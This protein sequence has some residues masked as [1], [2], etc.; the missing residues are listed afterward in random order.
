MQFQLRGLDIGREFIAQV[1]AQTHCVKDRDLHHFTRVLEVDL[2]S[3]FPP[4]ES[5]LMLARI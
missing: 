3:L 1:E 4:V 5:P 2:S